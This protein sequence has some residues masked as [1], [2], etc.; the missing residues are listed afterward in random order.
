M[1]TVLHRTGFVLCASWMVCGLLRP[2]VS[3]AQERL[4]I[5]PSFA[6]YYAVSRIRDVS[7]R[8]WESQRAAPAVA[9][10][11]AFRPFSQFGLEAAASY[12]FSSLIVTEEAAA[13][14]VDLSRGGNLLHVNG[15]VAFYPQRS[16][17]KLFAG[18]GIVRRGGEVWSSDFLDPE[19]AELTDVTGVVG[20]SI[21]AGVTPSFRLDI[22]VEANLYVSDPDGPERTRYEERFQQDL[23]LV[24]GIPLT[25]A[26]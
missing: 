16:T 24:I 5:V 8:D 7:D 26:R 13:Q 3:E 1:K 10:R 23:L 14:P 18:G 19:T 25:L 11:L 21:R 4:A 22:G 6:S 2:G 17:L 20:F 9:A 15:R 12:A